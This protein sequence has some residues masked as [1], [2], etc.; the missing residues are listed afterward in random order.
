MTDPT[1]D[2]AVISTSTKAVLIA[3][4]AVGVLP[5]DDATITTVALA[6]AALVDLAIFLGLIRPRVTPTADPR[7]NDGTRLVRAHNTN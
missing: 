5:W 3:L 7:A 2:A 1:R 4:V 6:V